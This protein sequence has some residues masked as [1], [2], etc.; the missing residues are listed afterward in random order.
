[1]DN[2]EKDQEWFESQEP[3]VDYNELNRAANVPRY[4][5]TVI[6]FLFIYRLTIKL[7][8]QI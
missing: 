2:K 5:T 8:P 3:E 6:L 4:N 1:M 7:I